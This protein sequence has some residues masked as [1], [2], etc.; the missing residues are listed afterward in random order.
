[1]KEKVF[2]DN[3]VILDIS[4]ERHPYFVDAVKTIDLIEK[5]MC[6]GYTSSVIFTNTYYIQRKLSD[7]AT[8]IHFLKKLRILLTVLDV[9]DSIIQE[10]LESDFS[11][12]EDAV[13]YYTA[14]HNG[15][16]YIITRNPTDFK[17]SKIPV[18]TPKEFIEIM[19]IKKD[20][21][22]ITRARRRR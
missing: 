10:A 16:D 4:T 22:T 11:D 17:K 8:A 13:Q 9:G 6:S 15:I 19:H 14:V 18:Y 20:N 21:G 12:F 7:H 5:G 2:I 3:N 1:M